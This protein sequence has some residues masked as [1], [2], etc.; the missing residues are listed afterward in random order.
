MVANLR[1]RIALV[2]GASRG[3][4]AAIANQLAASG[5]NVAVNCKNNIAAGQAV[6]NELLSLGARAM[7]FPCDVGDPKDIEGL[8]DSIEREL[9][10]IDILVNNAGYIPRPS[11]WLG[12]AGENLRRTIDVNLLSV[13]NMCRLFAPPMTEKGW[14]RIIN[15]TST[16]AFTGSAEILAYTAAKAGI[17]PITFAL[18]RELGPGGVTV[19]AIAPGNFLT[20]MIK[21]APQGYK[22]WVETSTPLRRFGKPIEAAEAALFLIASDYINGHVL[23]VDGGHILNM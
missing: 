2:T 16:Y 9:G 21:G 14:G 11:D 1:G 23:T 10:S 3:I 4:G 22:N 20:D 12:L 5:C 7:L 17:L 13:L 18:A 8:K 19:N 6:V 15:V